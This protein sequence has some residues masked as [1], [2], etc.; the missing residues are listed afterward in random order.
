MRRVIHSRSAPAL[1]AQR[2]ARARTGIRNDPTPLDLAQDLVKDLSRGHVA[3][4]AGD[5]APVRQRLVRILLETPHPLTPSARLDRRGAQVGFPEVDQRLQRNRYRLR[6]VD[7]DDLRPGSISA[8]SISGTIYQ[9]QCPHSRPT[10]V[11]A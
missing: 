5:T 7:S 8:G 4:V 1:G 9:G 2:A 10:N 6:N 3:A 11:P